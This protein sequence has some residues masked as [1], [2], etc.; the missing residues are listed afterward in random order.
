V[1]PGDAILASG[2]PPDRLVELY[3]G[4]PQAPALICKLGLRYVRAP[5]GL[6]VAHFQLIEEPL[7]MRRG[8]RWVPIT[9]LP[10]AQ[11]LIVL[12]SSTLPN[13]EGFYPALEFGFTNE[14][15]PLDF[16]VVR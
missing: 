14:A 9:G 15:P 1:R 4:T 10:G 12:T 8:D 5:S 2:Q 11:N 7:V 16:W 6:W 13:A 3:S